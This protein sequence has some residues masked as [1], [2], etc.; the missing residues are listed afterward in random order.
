M[1]DRLVYSS[2][3]LSGLALADAAIAERVKKSNKP[4][5]SIRTG[6]RTPRFSHGGEWPFLSGWLGL[7]VKPLHFLKSCD[8]L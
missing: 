2:E 7:G 6:Q 8:I 3:T 5:Q 4:P 1:S